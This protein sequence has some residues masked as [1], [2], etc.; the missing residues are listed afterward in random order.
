MTIFASDLRHTNMNDSAEVDMD[1]IDQALNAMHDT[2]YVTREVIDDCPGILPLRRDLGQSIALHLSFLK[3]E[4][5][6]NE[7]LVYVEDLTEHVN[8]HYGC[9]S[10][11]IR[12]YLTTTVIRDGETIRGFLGL[13]S[14][15]CGDLRRR[16]IGV[17]F[18]PVVNTVKIKVTGSRF[19]YVKL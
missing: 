18:E 7:D 3:E 13:T 11:R 17:D 19:F 8:Q 1:V 16:G 5:V 6:V 9:L 10:A 14:K 4:I 2:C 15:H 12:D